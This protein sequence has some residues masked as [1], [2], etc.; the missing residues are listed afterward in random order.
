M[1]FFGL[2]EDQRPVPEEINRPVPNEAFAFLKLPREIRDLIYYYALIR[3]GSGPNVEPARVCY[4]HHSASSRYLSTSYWGTE[5]STRLFRVSH[6][7]YNEASSIFY[8]AF[9]FY[10]PS[11]MDIAMVN[12]TL[13]ILNIRSRNLI[14]KLGFVLVFRSI[15]SPTTSE[16]DEKKGR[17]MEAALKLLPNVTQV[18]ATVALIGHDVP[19]WQIMAVVKR[20]L[21]TLAPLKDVPT[22]NVRGSSGDEN[23]RL[24][25]LREVGKALASPRAPSASSTSTS[26]NDSICSSGS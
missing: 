26:N 6:Q 2:K 24:Q 11:H 17:A 16:N 4:M 15:Q 25:I 8:S 9:P 19:K 10:F 14:Q 20:I 22:I 7:V 13:G 5:K 21:E 1:A 23:Q 12:D 3:P 18:E